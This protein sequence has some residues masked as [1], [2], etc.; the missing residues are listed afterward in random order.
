MTITD[1]P[2]TQSNGVQFPEPAYADIPDLLERARDLIASEVWDDFSFGEI[3]IGVARELAA[4]RQEWLSAYAAALPALQQP[5]GAVIDIIEDVKD[6]ADVPDYLRH[7]P[8]ASPAITVPNRISINGIP[9]MVTADGPVIERIAM[10][11]DGRDAAVVTLK[12]F[13][14]RIRVD[15]ERKPLGDPEP[16]TSTD[17]QIADQIAL[18]LDKPNPEPLAD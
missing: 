2:E 10:N 1:L 13:A 16:D 11:V 14:R 5:H 4:A 18:D 17:D 7:N 8:N 15:A 9:L 6:R 12:V 3:Q